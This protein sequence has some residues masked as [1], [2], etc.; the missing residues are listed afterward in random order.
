MHSPAGGWDGGVGS[1]GDW[2]APPKSIRGDGADGRTR[3]VVQTRGVDGTENDEARA[4][5][6]SMAILMV[7]TITLRY[8]REP[9]ITTDFGSTLPQLSKLGPELYYIYFII[10]IL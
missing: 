5:K 9:G 2:S 1:T 7:I 6:P 4:R 10:L 3:V 8:E